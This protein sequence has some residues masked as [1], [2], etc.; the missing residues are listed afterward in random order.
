MWTQKRLFKKPYFITQNK[1]VIK[2]VENRG[3]NTGYVPNK[4][5]KADSQRSCQVNYKGSLSLWSL[6]PYL[7]V[8]GQTHPLRLRDHHPLVAASVLCQESDKGVLT[9]ILQGMV[10]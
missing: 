1:A 7:V 4:Q 9:T 6:T 2:Q 3:F 8:P 5:G 10:N